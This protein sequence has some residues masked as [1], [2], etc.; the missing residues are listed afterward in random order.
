MKNRINTQ[1]FTLTR[2][3]SGSI[4]PMSYC[5]HP[6]HKPGRYKGEVLYKQQPVGEFLLHV[7][8]NFDNPQVNVELSQYRLNQ[9]KKGCSCDEQG[10]ADFNLKAGGYGLFHT[11]TGR[12]GYSVRVFSLEGEREQVFNSA[13]LQKDDLFALSLMRPGAY[14]VREASSKQKF[15]LEVAYIKPGKEKYVP[16]ETLHL[17]IEKL[18]AKESLNASPLQGIVFQCR[19]G[20]R[21]IIELEKPDEGPVKNLPKTKVASWKKVS[22]GR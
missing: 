11:V 3:D 6:F 12:D 13:A 1:L 5:L 22:S 9:E 17:S 14:S 15:G 18:D 16:P 8:D 10:K 21:I 2:F 7:C 20:E 4:G 19:K